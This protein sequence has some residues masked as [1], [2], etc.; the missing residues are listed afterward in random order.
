[1]YSYDILYPPLCSWH[2]VIT[3]PENNTNPYSKITAASQ[4]KTY[5]FNNIP[6]LNQYVLVRRSDLF[7]AAIATFLYYAILLELIKSQYTV[8]PPGF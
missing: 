1:M 2:T 7:I 8:P 4:R 5:F 6:E 3:K